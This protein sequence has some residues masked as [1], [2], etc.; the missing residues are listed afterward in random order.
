MYEIDQ[1]IIF[2]EI[3]RKSFFLTF[4]GGKKPLTI[5]KAKHENI[6]HQRFPIDQYV[7]YVPFNNNFILLSLRFDLVAEIRESK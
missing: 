3:R 1:K 7:K 4:I 6:R 5:S 2:C